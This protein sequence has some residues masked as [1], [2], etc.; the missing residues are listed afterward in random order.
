MK[1]LKRIL[2]VLALLFVVAQFFRPT[3][4][5]PPIVE[6]KVLHAPANVQAILD[7][8]CADC[9]SSHTVYPWYSRISPVSWWLAG[10]IK[11]GRREL[12]F[13]EAGGYTEKRT[14]RKMTEICE[15]VEKGE[16]PL[17]SYLPLHPAAKLS[18]ADKK[19]LCD[20]T[21]SEKQ[22]INAAGAYPS[23]S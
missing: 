3:F 14:L 16:M 22:R 13:D 2:L 12:N 20:W 23:G 11:D 19:T 17:K 15:Q 5:N 1:W 6:A 8:S 7:R 18:D 9:H 4:A 21:R 10:H